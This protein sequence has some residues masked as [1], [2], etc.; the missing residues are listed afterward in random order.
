MVTRPGGNGA[1]RSG[2]E[3]PNFS[4]TLT[5]HGDNARTGQNTEERVLSLANVNSRQFGKL[6]SLPVDGYVYAQPL[7]V[8]HVMIPGRGVHNVIYVATEH[9]SV[10]AFDADGKSARPLWHASFINPA[11][12]VT[13][14]P[15]D[16][17]QCGDLVPEVG[18]T[19][20][21]VIDAA[22]GTLYAV[23]KTKEPEGYVQRLHALD[24][25]TGREKFGGPATIAPSSPGL[26]DGS[27]GA[28]VPF[29]ALWQLNRAALLL[30][31]GV[32][33][34]AFG[35]HCDHDPY[36]GWV[37][38]YDGRTLSPTGV[39]NSTPNAGRGGIW[40]SGNGPAADE[41][42]DVYVASGNGTFDVNADGLDFGDSF[43]KLT[44]DLMLLDYFTPDNHA[45]LDG[46]D[47]DVGPS[48][49]LLL[50]AQP[51]GKPHL[52][53]GASKDG[54]IY[55]LDRDDLGRFN[56]HGNAQIV[57]QIR[58]ALRP[59]MSVPAYWNNTIYFAAASDVLKAFRLENGRL[60]P[61]PVSKGQTVFGHP[62]ASPAVSADKTGNGIVWVVKTDGY[63]HGG[64]AVLYAY[65][66]IDVSHELYNSA[67]AGERDVA[68]PAVKFVVPT[69]A[70]GRVYVGTQDRLTVFG[71]LTG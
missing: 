5:Y 48:G 19:G 39:F 9:D 11:A 15:A 61:K 70:N 56:A 38:G 8:P 43:L 67:E 55:V 63:S 6:F 26:G 41:A 3:R 52:L 14:V 20:T 31:R 17:L 2:S 57:Q 65:D 33:Y 7:Y 24:I 27:V 16:D 71:L 34:V 54:T 53:V 10:F 66:A 49:A 64:Q 47:L 29:D 28:D 30:S 21:P 18:I 13:T 51:G 35:S 69:V 1:S 25:A 37:L 58:A 45:Y 42:G 32:V 68:G 40:Q 44:P 4:G 46:G 62:G 59:L 36:H 60:N 23:V 50:P 22:T 12:G